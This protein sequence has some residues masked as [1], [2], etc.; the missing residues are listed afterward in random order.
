MKKLKEFLFFPLSAL[1]LAALFVSLYVF[2]TQGVS[3]SANF[4][5]L[6]VLFS[7]EFFTMLKDVFYI[8]F[9]ISAGAVVIATFVLIFLKQK[10]NLKIARKHFYY[11]NAIICTAVTFVTI[12][13][14]TS[15]FAEALDIN[16]S[17][18]TTFY[19][20]ILSAF[21]AVIITLIYWII[22]FVTTLIINSYKNKKTA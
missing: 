16:R 20:L 18:N 1:I 6:K 4:K 11:T 9:L 21:V 22:E 7:G 19:T 17:Q 14:K 3:L 2:S 12:F 15:A 5:S 10:K 8:P 13:F